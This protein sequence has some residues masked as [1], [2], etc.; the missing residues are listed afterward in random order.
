MSASEFLCSPRR[1]NVVANEKCAGI[2]WG[3]LSQEVKPLVKQHGDNPKALWEALE[4]LFAPRK[5]GARFNAYKTL[6]S[7]HLGEDESLL[8]LT[9]H[10]SAAIRLLKDSRT[11]KFTLENADKELQ[12][13]AQGGHH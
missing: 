4:A 6:A 11:A 3:M 12:A 1:H 10:V 5:D 8:S 7:I 2:L 9:G 13:V